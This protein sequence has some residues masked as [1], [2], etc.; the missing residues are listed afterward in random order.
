MTQQNG[1]VEELK[2]DI[3]NATREY[4]RELMENPWQVIAAAVLL[5]LLALLIF[6]K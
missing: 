3:A 5:A 1:F 6:P 2:S 4:F